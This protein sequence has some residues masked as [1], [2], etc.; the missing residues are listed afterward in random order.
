MEG[1]HLR[2]LMEEED[3]EHASKR[4]KGPEPS[5]EEAGKPSEAGDDGEDSDGEVKI[6]HESVGKEG[7]EGI[8]GQEDL[9]KAENT[10]FLANVSTEAI[11]SKQAKKTLEKHLSSILD[12]TASPPEKLESIRFRSLAF[13]Q[14]ALPKRAAYI[15]KSLMD[16]TTKSCNAYAVYNTPAAAR[17]AVSKLNAT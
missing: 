6:V 11:N 2:K 17:K 16:T 15:T 3:A 8:E 7:L 10:V 9:D 12:K 4:T 14:M 5:E 1:R 13:S